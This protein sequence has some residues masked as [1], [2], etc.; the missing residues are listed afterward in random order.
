MSRKFFNI[1]L[2][3]WI[4]ASVPAGLA[5]SFSSRPTASEMDEIVD[6][7]TEC[8]R[9]VNERCWATQYA[10]NP[11]QYHVSPFTN[12]SCWYLDQ[13]LMGS[14][15][16]KARYLVPFY[17]NPD[18]VY[19]GT[20]NI[21]MLSVTGVWAQ[22]EIGDRMRQF[23][24]TLASGTNPPTYGDYPWRIYSESLEERYKALDTL[25]YTFSAGSWWVPANML[26]SQDAGVNGSNWVAAKAACDALPWNPSRSLNPSYC[27]SG[28]H[29]FWW[30]DKHI[31]SFYGCVVGLNT[32]IL[33]YATFYFKAGMTVP[34]YYTPEFDDFGLGYIENH[35]VVIEEWEESLNSEFVTTELIG[36]EPSQ[37]AWIAMPWC[38]EPLTNGGARGF[39]FDGKGWVLGWDFQYCTDE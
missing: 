33:H 7:G 19:D 5:E 34:G 17:V 32:N 29:R 23:L 35:Y 14:I 36:V 30:A 13:N 20:T 25:A 22:L 6:L 3:A 39:S 31:N 38:S 18:T 4:S 15:A 8:A 12:N 27:Y 37:A 21:V 1:A 28:G 11:V 9:G 16:S 10:T 24:L 2:A 26:N